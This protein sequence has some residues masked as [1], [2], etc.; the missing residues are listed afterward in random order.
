MTT[1][2]HIL[3]VDDSQLDRQLVRDVLEREHTGFILTEASSRQEF[4]KR[5]DEGNYDLVLSDFNI[6]GFEGLQVIEAVRAKSPDIPVVVITGTGSEEVAV[7]AM[8]KGAADYVIK[9]PSHVKRLPLTI[10]AAL[11]KKRLEKQ[12]EHYERMLKES[13]ERFRLLYEHAPVG[14]QS[15]DEDGLFL[16]VN[17]AWVDLLGYSRD[18]VI[19]KWFG[20]F[21]APDWE[22]H[23]ESN[24]PCFK[25]AGEIHGV[26]FEMVRKDGAPITVEF[27]GRI[28]Y[29]RAGNFKQTHCIL[30]DVTELRRV[31]DALRESE[32]TFRSL[33]ENS[34]DAILL[35]APDGRIFRANPQACKILGCR[36]NE[37]VEAGRD[38]VID[39]TDPRLPVLLEERRLT[40]SASGELHFRRKDGTIFPAEVS[41]SVFVDANGQQRTSMSIRDISARKQAEN[42]LRET[43]EKYRLLFEKGKDA[44]MLHDAESMRFLDANPAAE[45]LWGYTKNELLTM[46]PVDLS[47]E[48]QE[49]IEALEKA[50]QPGGTHV[51]IR[52]QRQKDGTQIVVEVSMSQPFTSGNNNVVCS[53]VRD[54]TDRKKAEEALRQNEQKYRLIVENMHDVVYQTDMEGRV[55]FGSPSSRQ[56]LG[57]A[58]EEL[59]DTRL[60][61]LY[62]IPGERTRF[63]KLLRE[64]GSV[65]D[66]EAE[67]IRKDGSRVWASTNAR[68]LTDEKG[69]PVGVEGVTR[70]ISARKKAEETLRDSEERFRLAFDDANIGVCLV[71][72]Q[73]RMLKVNDQ[74][75]EMFGYSRAELEGM[76]V[77]DI[78][79]PEDTELSPRFMDRASSGEVDRAEFE[80]RYIHKQGHVVWGRVSS[81]LVRDR[82]GNPLY[83][84]S[85]V[86][87]LT[88]H[89][90][91]EEA[92]K[93]SEERFRNLVEVSP[94]GIAVH[95]EGRIVFVNPAGARMLGAE[96]RE[97]LMGKPIQDIVHP[98]CWEEAGK[99]IQRMLKGETGLYP[100]EDCYVKLDGTPLPVEVVA[101]PFTYKG[102][103]AVQVVARDIT[104]RKRAEQTLRESEERYRY[105]V[106]NIEDFICTH[107][108][109]GNLLFVS[110]GPARLL[111]LDPADIVGTNLRSYLAPEVRDQ[112]DNMLAA[113]RKDGRASGLMLV[114]SS[115]GEKRLW[116]YRNTLHTG[117]DGEPTVI[118]I[119]RDVTER[120]RA[121][122]ALRESQ[123]RYQELFNESKDGVYITALDGQLLDANQAFCEILGY[124]RDD[125]VGQDIRFTYVN[126]SDRDRFVQA[127]EE[128]GFLKDYPLALRRRDGREVNCL[129]T[130]SVRRARDGAVIGYHGILR[131]ITE[132]R[133][134]QNQLLQAQKMEAIGTLAG[135][136][137][138]D[139]NN[140]LQVALG[141]SE[142]LLG[143]DELPRRHKADLKKINESTKRGAELVQRL[144]NFSRKAEVKV[145]PLSLN[146][147]VSEMRKMIERTIPKM[148]DI[149]LILAKDLATINADPT[150]ID[151][152]LMNL[153]VNA[154]DAM[155]EGGKLI[156]ET[157]NIFLNK[158]YVRMHLDA[159]VGHHVLLM[160]TDTGS[161][162]DKDTV[163]HIFEPFFTTK[164]VGEGTGLGLAMVHGIVTHSG[165]HVRCYSEIGEGTT[166]KIY[167][168]AQ[169]ADEVQAEQDA[170]P[171]PPGG[172]ETILL[173]DDEEFIL[174]LGSRILTKA[175]YKVIKA[176][177]GKEAQEVYQARR[178][179]IALVILDLIMPEMG[180]KQCLEILLGL[181][182][183]V[184]VVIASGYSADGPT[185]EAL[186]A[187]AKGF[188]NKPYDIRQVLE[189]IRTVLDQ[190][191]GEKEL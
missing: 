149:Q 102:K 80:K 67:L 28:G 147:R 148:I 187:G 3:Y 42:L 122:Q 1:T 155:P 35:T 96:N 46:T 24:F 109:K 120:R 136:V 32:E 115:S 114:Q 10:E 57:Y 161:G 90:R 172:S 7:E 83:F 118:G 15:L 165:G 150:Q 177:N 167:F 185:K 29:D 81:S 146:R 86:Q 186:S 50:A 156:I 58:P 154:R 108:L 153:A 6:L 104:D 45:A 184:K 105:V 78:A 158:E 113:V 130:S 162:M 36:E 44:V 55:I 72:P 38:G 84:V 101:S 92:A 168:P 140:V 128:S 22:E 95:Q 110:S 189:V 129:L 16:E 18:E 157:A 125:V 66:F 82:Q 116:E 69:N 70:D 17:Q 14:Y 151:Q 61:A 163:E 89:K 31:Q 135:G 112:F 71:D 60:S 170:R 68:L 74:M 166:F 179:S 56:L 164:A 87:D 137:A 25:S 160:V 43:E 182:P 145:Q 100:V 176:S 132:Q 5:L 20:H 169:V 106:E 94:D 111:G 52:L 143:D 59:L 33:F 181:N 138:H 124:A 19:G 37:I 127:I 139:F 142:L 159:K 174:D 62:A 63:L 152:V 48:R 30:R 2:I 178:D 8:K 73:G 91:A 180:G 41:S 131:D 75:C 123:E 49:T 47:L 183:S 76:T 79:H 64:S 99:R 103:P 54:I 93:E 126:P 188:V 133:N 190:G 23:F 134:L 77:N 88:D 27:D 34:L 144:L 40:G 53:I 12:H 173:V 21:V 65:T 117:T 171:M 39:T 141:Y 11:E 121:E 9:S 97:D 26:Q 175:G 98:D 107:D 191:Q 85:H 51:P 119:A 13:E 4:E